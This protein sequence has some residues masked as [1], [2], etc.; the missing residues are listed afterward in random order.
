[1]NEEGTPQRGRRQDELLQ[2]AKEAAASGDPRGMVE[3]L[4]Q[5]FALDSLARWLRGKWPTLPHDDVDFAVAEAVDVL[6][7]AVG[8]GE[9]VFKIVAYLWKVSDRKA[10]EHYRIRVHEIAFDPEELERV[11]SRSSGVSEGSDEELDWE[12]RRGRAIA[13]A[14][15]LIPRLG[16]SSIRAVMSYVIDA[17]EAGCED[18]PSREI[19]EALGLSDDTVRQ[20]LSRGF[21]KLARIV[22]EE[23]LADQELDF[24]RIS[25]EKEG[26]SSGGDLQD[27]HGS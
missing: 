27:H 19:A 8:R 18:L 2:K 5:S 23:G 15:S 16:Q 7:Q 21:R 11:G 14:R 3:A 6:Y 9:K 24:G 25:S 26:T 20:S 17:V 13:I 1:M 12:E 4:Y 22:R 10:G